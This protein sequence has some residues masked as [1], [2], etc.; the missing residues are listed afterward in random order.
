MKHMEE[1]VASKKRQRQVE[2]LAWKLIE[3]KGRARDF[4]LLSVAAPD[5]ASPAPSAT[6]KTP[7]PSA[8]L[9]QTPDLCSC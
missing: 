1:I 9:A 8:S 5:T 6:G 7:L 3:N 4:F 2:L